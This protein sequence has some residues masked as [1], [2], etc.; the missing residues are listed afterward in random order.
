M[1]SQEHP[2]IFL[3]SFFS[4]YTCTQVKWHLWV[5]YTWSGPILRLQMKGCSFMR[6]SLSLKGTLLW[7]RCCHLSWFRVHAGICWNSLLRVSLSASWKQSHGVC[8]CSFIPFTL[9][10][11]PCSASQQPWSEHLWSTMCVH[12]DVPARKPTNHGRST[13]SDPQ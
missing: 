2:N 4:S 1:S 10:L 9:A 8:V 6:F 3:C 13:L 5:K 11:F 12:H 7:L